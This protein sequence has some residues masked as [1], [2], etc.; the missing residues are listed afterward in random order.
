[1]ESRVHDKEV[2]FY[3]ELIG[4]R[5]DMSCTDLIVLLRVY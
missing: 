1:M 2:F 4:E 5:P 3:V